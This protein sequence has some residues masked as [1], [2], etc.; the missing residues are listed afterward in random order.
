MKFYSEITKELYDSVDALNAAE[1][2]EENKKHEKVM[3]LIDD[4]TEAQLDVVEI[5]GEIAK[6]TGKDFEVSGL[7]VNPQGDLTVISK[8]GTY[9]MVKADGTVVPG[10]VVKAHPAD[11]KCGCH[12][13]TASFEVKNAKIDP[14]VLEDIFGIPTGKVAPK[15]NPIILDGHKDKKLTEKEFMS[16]LEALTSL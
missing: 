11:C 8:D 13:N 12:D 10:E 7:I 14:K 2:I 3:E 16:L 15:A 5:A 6:L 9:G 1:K 4:L